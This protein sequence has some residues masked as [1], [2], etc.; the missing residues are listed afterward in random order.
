MYQLEITEKFSAAH[1]LRDYPGVCARIHGH[2][3]IL[4]IGFT[5]E[6]TDEHGMTID[7]ADLK[8]II[9]HVIEEFDHNL[10]NDHPY[11]KTVNPTSEKIAEYMYGRLERQLPAKIQMEY[12]HIAETEN[13]SV[14]YRK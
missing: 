8:K 4:K 3:W 9:G 1:A 2:N 12:V 14:T 10:F 13:F 7:Y 6:T 5:A 11:F